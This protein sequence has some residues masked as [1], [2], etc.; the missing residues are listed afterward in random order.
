MEMAK[1]GGG[2]TRRGHSAP[3]RGGNQR[4]KI[5]VCRS[6]EAPGAIRHLFSLLSQNVPQKCFGKKEICPSRSGVS[7]GGTVC[8]AETGKSAENEPLSNT[9]KLKFGDRYV[10]KIVK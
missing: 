10:S 6:K 8:N 4:P 7:R 1:L 3:P 2:L 5:A 9:L